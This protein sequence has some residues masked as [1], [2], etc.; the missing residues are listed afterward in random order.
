MASADVP[1][2]TLKTSPPQASTSSF[3]WISVL[4]HQIS[5]LEYRIDI[6]IAISNHKP[7]RLHHPKSK[8][9]DDQ[10]I[11]KKKT[12]TRLTFHS[13]AYIHP[14]KNITR[15]PILEINL[16][17][18]GLLLDLI[19]FTSP[20]SFYIMSRSTSEGPSWFIYIYSTELGK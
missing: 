4:Y 9:W 5:S 14:S 20:T 2:L 7:H 11:Q 16:F 13:T 19:T 3:E 1:H 18:N 12:Y 15:H 10:P 6:S 17:I 8:T